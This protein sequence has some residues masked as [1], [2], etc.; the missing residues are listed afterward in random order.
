[1]TSGICS[2]PVAVAR[3]RRYEIRSAKLSVLL[4]ACALLAACGGGPAP[5]PS[6]DPDVPIL[7]TRDTQRDRPSALIPAHGRL[8]LSPA[9]CF[10]LG[11]PGT[12]VFAPDGS[13]VSSD[14]A[15]IIVNGQ[16]Y[17][18]GEYLDGV[19]GD[20]VPLH[21]VADATAELIA[22]KPDKVAVLSKY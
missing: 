8:R 2:H 7:A 4:V 6:I 15:G 13:T 10:A 9:N 11:E 14:G 12:V 1:M 18:L 17:R 5:A 19:G 3:L 20:V 16:E 21:R 22:C